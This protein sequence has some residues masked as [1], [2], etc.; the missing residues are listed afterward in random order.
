MALT[1]IVEKLDDLVWE[2]GWRDLGK[3][4]N[5]YIEVFGNKGRIFKTRAVKRN[6]RPTWNDSFQ[7]SSSPSMFT[8]RLFHDAPGPDVTIA[9][10]Q[11]SVQHFMEQP[12]S[13]DGVWLDMKAPDGKVRGR[14][15]VRLGAFTADEA[16]SQ[17]SD[18]ASKLNRQ[19]AVV[20][21]LEAADGAQLLA[22]LDAIL[23]GLENIVKVGDELAKIHPYANA[24]WKA[25]TAVYNITRNQR[26]ADEK[27]VKLVQAMA[28]L[29]SFAKNLDP[30][31]NLKSIEESVLRI[32]MQTLECAL[33]I[34]EYYGHGFL[35]RIAQTSL[36]A[37]QRIDQLTAA[38]LRLA[39]E[40][41][42]GLV[43]QTTLLSA[44]VLDEVEKLGTSAILGVLRHAESSL[45]PSMRRECLPGTRGEIIEAVTQQL[46]TP[47]EAR[48]VWLS[49]VAGSGKSTVATSL[50]GIQSWCFMR[51]HSG[52]PK[53]TWHLHIE[54]AICAALDRDHNLVKAP[55]ENQFRELLLVP[56]ESVKQH[57]V[58]PFVVVIDALDECTED[59]RKVLVNLI[60]DLFAKLPAAF[61]FFVT[62]RLDSDITRVLRNNI[63]VQEHSL[64]IAT[65]NPSDISLYI[66]DRLDTIRQAHPTLRPNWPGEGKAQQLI[67]LSGNLFI[68]AATALD[69]IEGKKM[70]PPSRRLETMLE[71]PFGTGGNLDRLY[72]LALKSDGDWDDTEFRESATVVLAGIAL[73][74][75][76]MTEGM[77]DAVLGLNDGTAAGVLPFLGSLVYWSP[78]QPVRT[79][80][81]SFGDFLVKSRFRDPWFSDVAKV[82]KNIASGCFAVLEKYLKFNICQLPDSDLPNPQNVHLPPA[83][84]YASRFWGAHVCDSDFDPKI[85]VLL[86]SFLTGQFLF[87]LEVLS[88]QQEIQ[89]AAGTLHFAQR[90]AQGKSDWVETFLDDGK[91]FVAVFGPA[92]AQSAAHIYISAVALAPRLSAIRQHYVAWF[93]RL[94]RYNVPQTWTSLE[95]TLSHNT[96]VW[97]VAFSPDGHR[98]VSGSS[99]KMVRIWD[100]ATGTLVGGLLRG[101]N[102]SVSCVALSLDGHRIVSGSDDKTVRVWD[103]ATGAAVGEPLQG[104]DD[105]VCSVAFSPDGRRIVSGSKD[106]TV[107]IW[108]AATGAAVGAPLEHNGW[109]CSVAFLSDGR[110]IVSGSGDKMVRIW[111]PTTGAVV[112]L[113]HDAPV[114]S[115]ALSPDGHR[116]ASGS[117][118]HTVRIWDAATGNA[119]RQPLQGHD[120][121]VWSVAFS[122]DGQQIASGSSDQTVR[123]WDATTVAAGE[124]LQGHSAE[125]SS[126][127][128]SPDGHS[129]ISGA[130]DK[131]V[132]IWDAATGAPARNPLKGHDGP[133]LSIALSP[134]GHQIVSGSCDKTVRVWDAA[135]G[136]AV[137]APLE[138]HD[139]WVWSVAFSPDGQRIISGSDDKTLRIWDTATG[140]VVLLRGHDDWVWSVAF[141]P[142]GR[143]VVSG[144]RDKTVRIW[145]AATGAAV[146]EPLRGHTAAASSVAFS[147]DGRRIVSGSGDNMVRIWDVATSAAVGA[148][149]QGHDDWVSSVTFSPNG[150]YIASASSDKS[151]RIWDAATG[152]AVGQPPRGHDDRV[153]SVAFSP[154]GRRIVSG[155]R[156]QTV[157]IWDA[158]IGAEVTEPL[159]GYDPGVSSLTG[160]IP[161]GSFRD[162]WICSSSSSRLI[163][164]P[165]SLRRSFC[166]PWCCFVISPRGVNVLDL[167]NFVHGL[168]WEKCIKEEY[169][170]K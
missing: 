86:G 114:L 164:V 129:V 98:I 10:A 27:V 103:A 127:A 49:G 73:A 61:R 88:V 121:W 8:F 48:I 165:P 146:A 159:Q 55:F 104:H 69:F 60:A 54:Q 29:Y 4:P 32:T 158:V 142:D 97:S 105:R 66:R 91:K 169:R 28:T 84:T 33:F 92:I 123:V 154:D 83:L 151:I 167:S 153:C 24:A 17:M 38:L 34:R 141:S 41:D 139:G 93:P 166:M 6:I 42:Q 99:D 152:A 168:D 78:G 75:I 148:P 160:A 156:D 58:G 133:V 140:A 124:T 63:A 45:R 26:E 1:L 7:T 9:E 94:L 31:V 150:H 96:F 157:R 20:D 116:I 2:P 22:A 119:I 131:T 95:K 128:F 57:L 12:N 144:S 107:R 170:V 43:V 135:T 134:D 39:E 82:K 130:H 30:V 100:A 46:T 77:M 137:G 62:S 14:L 125:V 52:S 37:G 102:A 149:L 90:Y 80:H 65:A 11:I 143:R 3:P 113:R 53:P 72:T 23:S 85:L 110:R 161:R 59:S 44:Q 13:S 50:E 21:G 106:K 81:A 67:D 40:L 147:P 71:T 51:L 70:F 35:G 132:C 18:S 74:E 136:F 25:V 112:P 15:S 122:P 118:D 163:W 64:D 120:D 36:G 145:D 47:S 115:I 19:S 16:I 5:L 126:V 101:H 138:G 117:I 56:L 87:W 79:L 155:S 111:D 108:A 162:G 109:V 76:P 89:F 68:W